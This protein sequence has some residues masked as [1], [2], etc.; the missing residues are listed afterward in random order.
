MVTGR[1]LI[2]LKRP[3]K[4]LALHRQELRERLLAALQV[5]GDDHLPDRVDPRALEEHV[6]RPAKADA[7][8]AEGD[9]DLRL[10]GLV[11]VRPDAEAPCVVGPLHQ[12]IE[13]FVN[14]RLHG[15]IV[16]S[17]R[18]RSTSDGI[19]FTSP[20]KTSPVLPLIEM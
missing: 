14:L 8:R 5:L 13:I 7:L 18:T 12:R 17:T 20:T 10:P 1:P 3:A 19:V 2:T 11:G 9:G 4:S 16:L 6:L 15:F